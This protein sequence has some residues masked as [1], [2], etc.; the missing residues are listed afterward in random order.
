MEVKSCRHREVNGAKWLFIS[1]I[2]TVIVMPIMMMPIIMPII[3]FI[4]YYN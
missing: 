3:V 4:Y 1:K 2:T